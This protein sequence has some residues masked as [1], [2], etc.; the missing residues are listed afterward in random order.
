LSQP[1]PLFL[2]AALA[3]GLGATVARAQDV[4]EVARV[5]LE[6]AD[7]LRAAG[8]AEEARKRYREVLSAAPGV[9]AAYVGLGALEHAAGHPDEALKVFVTGL[10]QAPDDRTLL[11]NAGATAL[12]LGKPKDAL[13]YVDRALTRSEKDV[14][15]HM[16]RGA[17]LQKLD[18]GEDA[19]VDLQTVVR[20]DPGNARGYF[21]LGN[22]YF[23]LGKK[24]EAIDAFQKAVGQ[25]KTLLP[26]YYNLGAALF[27][28]QRYDEAL[29]AYEVA[30]A[31][32]D[33]E[34][35][36]GRAVDASQARAYLNLGGIY[37]QRQSWDRALDA[38]RKA[39]RLDPAAA[40]GPY[41][42]GYILFKMEKL[43]EAYEAYT[44]AAK[45]DARL[46]LANL[47]RALI[48]EKRG[49][50]DSAIALLTDALPSL[51]ADGQRA[52]RLARARAYR[53]KGDSARAQ[54]DYE[55]V[56][57]QRPED[58]EALVGLGRLLREGGRTAEART[59]LERARKV[60][61]ES[62]GVALELAA[63]AKA[64]G[65]SAKEKA[66]YT[67]ILKRDG[68]RPE[69]W[70]VH[71]SLA[72]LLAREGQGAAARA[73]LEPLLKKPDARR[74]AE[75]SKLLHSAYGMLLLKDGDK[76]G[77]TRELQAALKEDRSFAPAQ[78][79][80]AI[81]GAVGGSLDTAAAALTPLAAGSDFKDVRLLT[82]V[83]L[84]KVLWLLGRAAE[85][86][87]HL[88]AGAD[89]FP[90]DLAAQAALGEIALAAGDRTTAVRRLTAVLDGCGASAPRV[91][92]G[93][94]W[95]V[96]VGAEPAL[97]L[98]PRVKLV[99]GQALLGSAADALDRGRTEA[100]ALHE[101]RDGAERAL[102]LSLDGPPRAAALF[103]KGTAELMLDDVRGARRDLAAAVAG[104]L[105]AAIAPLAHNNL[106]AAL[107]RDGAVDE[108]Q[109]QFE[110]AR[111]QRAS[112]P[113]AALNL[114]LTL[115]GKP[116][117]Q[118]KALA[119]YEEY[120]ALGGARREDAQKWADAL[121]KV[122]R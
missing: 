50:T 72:M 60:V 65:D 97:W 81:L 98:C 55:A 23:R 92:K 11:F 119:L 4:P 28:A 110:A 70:P 112:L 5:A 82:R 52:A 2:A 96:S 80:L 86:K 47:H 26:A 7:R 79:A 20:L 17:V 10:A 29:K 94:L 58:V 115:H 33:K 24:T 63:L 12:Q 19:L 45:I 34:L 85:A 61:L 21:N 114:G 77:A 120:L 57:A 30:L 117:G 106:G 105:P 116:G 68:E 108:A 39:E 51:D 122:Y 118:Q 25:D 121:K 71:L 78:A 83:E 13:P 101:A 41:N 107:Y 27:E 66:L 111:A 64:E 37:S 87:P 53:G 73:Q 54:A 8:K 100:G 103:V 9:A 74:P 88:E 43:D 90:D 113:A 67:E 42:I 14:P 104:E 3:L 75:A 6:D 32:V 93:A 109:V 56:L 76:D 46:P 59:Q 35:A 84:G 16:L 15:L 18:R 49:R 40:A 99:L 1:T 62:S 31:P 95:R 36:A 22:A 102:A 89:A 44:R 69:M 38:Y 48:D 91:E